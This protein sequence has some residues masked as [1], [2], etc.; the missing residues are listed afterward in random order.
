MNPDEPVI[1]EPDAPI[2][3]PIDP[4]EDPPQ[5]GDAESYQVAPREHR[6]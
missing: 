3:S 5:A 2:Q 6:A 1:P 4:V